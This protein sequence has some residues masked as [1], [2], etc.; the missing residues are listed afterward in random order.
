MT[1]PDGKSR[2]GT[3]KAGQVVWEDGGSHQPENLTDKSFEAVRIELKD[4]TAAG[5]AK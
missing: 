1:M 4:P 3:G 2:E 5:A